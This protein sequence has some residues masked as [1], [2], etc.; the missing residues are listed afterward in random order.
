[1]KTD[2]D[3]KIIDSY[4]LANLDLFNTRNFDELDELDQSI[5]VRNILKEID[6]II[7]SLD[8]DKDKEDKE[9][10]LGKII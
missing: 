9:D 7:M 3:I 1:M 4:Q 8:V 6:V 2:D 5:E 10:K